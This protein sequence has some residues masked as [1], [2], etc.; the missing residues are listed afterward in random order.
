MVDEKKKKLPFHK[1]LL[2]KAMMKDKFLV[3]AVAQKDEM[4]IIAFAA[5]LTSICDSFTKAYVPEE[6][7][8]KI[9]V[10]LEGFENPVIDKLADDNEFME[11]Y[12]VARDEAIKAMKAE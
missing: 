3:N 1:V 5:I 7:R 6:A 2:S 4:A 10:V 12:L 8:G 11:S 9:A